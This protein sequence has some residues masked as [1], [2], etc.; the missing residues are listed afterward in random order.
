MRVPVCERGGSCTWRALG[1]TSAA[2]PLVAAGLVLAAEAWP[3]DQPSPAGRWHPILYGS[4]TVIDVTQGSNDLADVG[5]CDAGP[6]YDR[7]SG[8]GSPRFDLLVPEPG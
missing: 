7:A 5:C 1:G 2:A 3:D 8:L 4:T 6:G